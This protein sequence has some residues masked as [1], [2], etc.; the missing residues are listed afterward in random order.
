M[1]EAERNI[2]YCDSL[3]PIRQAE[4][5]EAV[6]GFVF[7]KDTAYAETGVYV[8]PQQTV[9]RNIERSYIRCGVNEEGEMYTASVYFGPGPVHHTGIRISTRDG[10]FV[11]T[12]SIPYDG[13]LN[14][15]FQDGGNTSEIVQ[16][17]GEHGADVI[18]FICNNARE[19]LRV[20]Y[21]GGTQYSLYMGEADKQ[22]FVSTYGLAAILSD[23]YRLTAERTKSIKK[24]DYLEGK[25]TSPV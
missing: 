24:K 3:L 25:L 6:K 5:M 1:K 4:A 12:A 13:G 9:E 21:T 14:Y 8:R 20:D 10:I 18:K 2:I 17:K 7:E 15:R 19:R 11:E 23:I 16:Y 22:A